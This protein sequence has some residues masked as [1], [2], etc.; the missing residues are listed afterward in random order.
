MSQ[1]KF[2]FDEEGKMGVEAD[3]G[4][5]TSDLIRIIATLEGMVTAYLKLTVPELRAIVDSEFDTSK[6]LPVI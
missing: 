4:V 3:N 6:V 5:N 2:T 1:I